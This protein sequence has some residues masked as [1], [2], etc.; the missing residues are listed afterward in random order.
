[1]G[2]LDGLGEGSEELTLAR[3][4]LHLPAGV[5]HSRTFVRWT[6]EF[7]V[8][9]EWVPAQTEPD[10]RTYQ[11]VE[12]AWSGALTHSSVMDQSI[13]GPRWTYQLAYLDGLAHSFL[14]RPGFWVVSAKGDVL[15]AI[16]DTYTHEQVPLDC[17]H[18]GLYEGISR[19]CGLTLGG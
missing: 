14:H 9:V 11:S 4:A 6:G 7:D 8:D 16:Y 5:H 19:D 18:R 17:D 2:R 13:G 10:G 15:D 1:M 12:F 3:R